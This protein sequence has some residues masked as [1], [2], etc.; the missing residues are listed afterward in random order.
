MRLLDQYLILE[1][2]LLEHLLISAIFPVDLPSLMLH[3][4]QMEC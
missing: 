1:Y 3:L 4:S 2:Q